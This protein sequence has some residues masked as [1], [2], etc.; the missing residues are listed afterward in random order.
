M[1]GVFALKLLGRVATACAI[2]MLLTI[3]LPF[4]MVR[5]D[6]ISARWL[7]LV[8]SALAVE[9]AAAL[10]FTLYHSRKRPT[11]PTPEDTP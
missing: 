1:G 8:P 9:I 2:A 7:G 6:W 11:P 10:A 5:L 4:A 3:A